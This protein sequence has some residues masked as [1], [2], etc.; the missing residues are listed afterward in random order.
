MPINVDSDNSEIKKRIDEVNQNKWDARSGY[1]ANTCLEIVKH[2][3][4]KETKTL[5]RKKGRRD[6]FTRRRFLIYK[7]IKEEKRQKKRYGG[8]WRFWW[9]YW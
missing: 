4:C 5:S 7:N 8:G 6:G 9:Q 2:N 3:E 1:M